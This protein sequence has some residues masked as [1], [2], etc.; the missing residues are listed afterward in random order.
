MS[1]HIPAQARLLTGIFLPDASVPGR[2]N[3]A[4][5]AAMALNRRCVG[6][7]PQAIQMAN[8]IVMQKLVKTA[9][10]VALLRLFANC[11]VRVNRRLHNDLNADLAIGDPI[12]GFR[13][14]QRRGLAR[15][16]NDI[17]GSDCSQ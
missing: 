8:E 13:F 1:P 16:T 15:Q 2:N 12:P 17:K 7:P 4:N 6:R 9:T 14:G 3:S 5:R 11:L 10:V